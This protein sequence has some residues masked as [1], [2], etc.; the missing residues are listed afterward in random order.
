[1]RKL[2]SI[3]LKFLL[4][5]IF[6]VLMIFIV[7][8]LLT[9]NIT[10]TC[11]D[12]MES[13]NLIQWGGD[14][15]TMVEPH[16]SRA[17]YT[18]LDAQMED[19]LKEKDNDFII[20]FDHDKQEFLRKGIAAT[21][22]QVELVNRKIL[23]KIK[24]P[25]GEYYAL[26]MPVNDPNTGSTRGYILYGHSLK[27]KNRALTSIRNHILVSSAVVF[28][29]AIL[30]SNFIIKRITKPI[31]TI[32]KGLEMVSQGNM[33]YRIAI[34]SRDEY[35][36]LADNFNKMAEQLEYM[37]DELES[38]QKDLENQVFRRTEALNSANE[39][40]RQAMDELKYTQKQII[41]V[42]TQKS[43][44]S[45]VS[46]FA[47]EINNPLTGILGYIDLMELNDSLSPYSQRRLEG[48]KDMALRIK[49]I[50][51]ELNQ[52]D[53]E[54]EGETA[55]QKAWHQTYL[56]MTPEQRAQWDAAYQPVL[57]KFKRE[58]PTGEALLAWKY[59]RYIKDYLR[60]V[61]SVDEN[62][63]RVLDYL[64]ENG[65]AENTIVVYTSDQGFYLGDHGWFDKRFM[66]EESLRM[67]C[68][69]RYPQE[70]T[71]GSTCDPMI[72][73]LDFAPTFLDFA[74]VTIP[75]EMQGESVRKLVRGEE[76]GW[77]NSVYY[78]YYEFPAVHQ[79]KKHYGIRTRDYKLIHFY[80]DI[81]AWELYDLKADPH[82]L[83]NLYGNPEIAPVV[84]QLQ[85]ELK[86]LQ[87]QYAD[88]TAPD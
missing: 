36:F 41:Q 44:T 20:L 5:F 81:D 16:F 34:A 56:R 77:R 42:E 87:L 46:G 40:L 35:G 7:S 22:A 66:Y 82:E 27:D 33:S 69:M 37:M 60:C 32:K 43:L 62:V 78:H 9:Q 8:I 64:D 50:I 29:L 63:G 2:R 86:Q 72:L 3:K 76:S 11:I 21:P 30:C 6:V 84:T 88:T 4:Y 48:I 23:K 51:D 74:G 71:P 55:N 25:A 83:N 14:F 52:L 75:A 65:L 31:D 68:L 80:E 70:I 12:E 28:A 45:I 49:D 59:Q 17:G 10:H 39:K 24:L 79:V 54:I 26:S 67:P 13:S 38:S 58:K 53:P 19:V 73:N 15:E 18:A 57:E 1:M 61:A 47:H 85:S